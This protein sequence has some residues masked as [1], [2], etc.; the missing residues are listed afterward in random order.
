MDWSNERY[1]RIYT[2]DSRNLKL[3]GW[4]GRALLWETIRKADRA[5]VIEGIRTA[6]DLA[7][8]VDMPVEVVRG[9]LKRIQS[10]DPDTIQLTDLGLVLPSYIPANE[11]RQ[12]DRQRQRESRARRAEKARVVTEGDLMGSQLVNE[13]GDFVTAGHSRSQPV[14]SCHSVPSLA[15]PSSTPPLGP[16]KGEPAKRRTR[17][18]EPLTPTDAHRT[19][20]SELN[21]DCDLE[22]EK[23][24]EHHMARGTVMLDWNRAFFT[25]LRKAPEFRRGPSRQATDAFSAQMS[26]VREL[27]AKEKLLT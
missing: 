4:E 23:F 9:A 12:S 18:K 22:A 19:K 3:F 11:A 10:V 21:L 17:L 27:E 16:P 24:S 25:W 7:L 6:D 20:A 8:M 14:T 1:V 15:V 5:G 2:R 13:Q 26:R